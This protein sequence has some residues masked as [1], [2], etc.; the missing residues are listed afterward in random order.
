MPAVTPFPPS[1]APASRDVA[2]TGTINATLAVGIVTTS[3]PG[4]PG[5]AEIVGPY[6]EYTLNLTIPQGPQGD[7]GIQG[8]PGPAVADGDKGDITVSS[9][10]TVWTIKNL[11]VSTAKLAAKAVTF[12]KMQD[13]ATG[14]FLG[15]STAGSGS[16][17]ELTGTQATTLLDAFTGAGGSNGVKGLVPA[18]L[19]ADAAAGRV[20]GAGGAWVGQ[21]RVLIQ[22]Q[23]ASNS[24]QIDFTTGL[25]DTFDAYEIELTSV[26]AATDD[27][28]LM[29]R[30]GTGAGPTWQT[31]GYDGSLIRSR[32]GSTTA[33][34]T[35]PTSYIGLTENGGTTGLG[36]ATGEKYR[37]T[38]KFSDPDS[39][40]FC[41]FTHEGSYGAALGN[42]AFV[43]GGGRYNT[44]GAITGI[45]FAM[46][47]GNIASGRFSLF[48]VRKT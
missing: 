45:R 33:A 26:K 5:A 17:E 13:I 24:A 41:E 47:S 16:P 11:I 30:V 12:A 2:A 10:S 25:D 35:N 29:L 8:V 6:P 46:S 27:V 28:A 22:T 20:L 42:S 15:R 21:P 1:N 40:D 43:N 7:Q 4:S 38:V 32:G 34:V 23:V 31:S 3:A 39:S 19:V 9:S 48:G 44:A 36:N 14:R 37:G 18:P